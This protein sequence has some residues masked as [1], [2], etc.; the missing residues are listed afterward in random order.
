MIDL[1]ALN[2]DIRKN[3]IKNIYIFTGLDEVLIKEGVDSI[4][5]SVLDNNFRELNLIRLDGLTTSFTDIRDNC[6][7]MPFMSD[8]KVVVVY[9]A[10]FLKD[11][12]DSASK[13]LYTDV[14][15][16]LKD[17]PD[18]CVLIM[19]YLLNDKRDRAEKNPKL[20]TLSK[21][22][23]IVKADKLKGEKYYK[24]VKE[25]FDMKNAD[26][27]RVELK[28][29]CDSIENNFTIIEREAEK[30]SSYCIGKTIT[31][32]SIIKMLPKREDEDV[33]DLVEFL[34]LKRPEKA[35]DLMNELIMRGE[36]VTKILSLVEMQMNMLLKVKIL[37]EEK[38]GKD[39]IGKEIGR[40]SFVAEK[41]MNQSRKFS[42]KSILYA[43][44]KC[45]ETEKVL[46]SSSGDKKM[47]M[48][49]LFLDITIK[50]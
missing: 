21:T 30:L 27:G 41:L 36:S 45:V 4:I 38:K 33:F 20:K 18:H 35:V 32:E 16:Y 19:Y 50:K 25:I 11:K 12:T 8:K 31:K 26:I 14:R 42:Y 39:Q 9:R 3:V 13:S 49:V 28:F 44:K 10:N 29:F 22:S 34:S 15:E 48:E 2:N 1:E 7:T 47:E 5:D 40:P 43:M 23:Q 24:K 6:E 37:M 17:I 46:K